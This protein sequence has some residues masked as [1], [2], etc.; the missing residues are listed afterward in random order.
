MGRTRSTRQPRTCCICPNA[1]YRSSGNLISAA[2]ILADDRFVPVSSKTEI[3]RLTI[4]DFRA[5][6]K[7]F[8]AS[9]KFIGS[10]GRKGG[11]TDGRTGDR[12]DQQ[13]S[14][15]SSN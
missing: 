10:R 11:R 13:V 14:S 6:T 2:S 12:M 1:A 3:Y 9:T 4:I 15:V 5:S 8:Y 7:D